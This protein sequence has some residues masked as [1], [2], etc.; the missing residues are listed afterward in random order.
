MAE[1]VLLFDSTAYRNVVCLGLLV[2]EDGRKMSKSLGNVIDPWEALD[3]QGADAL[4]WLM[5]TNGSPWAVATR[6]GLRS[7]TTS[8]ASSC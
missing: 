8:S 6:V 2:A 7:S 4:R 5:I 3:R 1:G